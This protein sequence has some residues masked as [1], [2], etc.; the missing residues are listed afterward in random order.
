MYKTLGLFT[1]AALLAVSPARA[2]LAETVSFHAV[3][4]GRTVVLANWTCWF[5]PPSCGYAPCNMHTV[6]DGKLGAIRPRVH[7]GS[8]PARGGECAGKPTTVLDLI[9]TPRPG[10]HGTDQI[11]LDTHSDNGHSNHILLTVE[12]P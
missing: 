5:G 12:V 3:A 2:Q 6:E 11:V 9:Y 8:I 1:V 7:A 4:H 10:A